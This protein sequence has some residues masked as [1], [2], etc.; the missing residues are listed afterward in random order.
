MG[1]AWSDEATGILMTR[2]IWRNAQIED[3]VIEAPG[4]VCAALASRVLLVIDV[5]VDS[6]Y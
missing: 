1:L 4:F 5:R 3:C 2:T 6:M